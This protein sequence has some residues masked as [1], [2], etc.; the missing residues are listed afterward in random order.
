MRAL[1]TGGNGFMGSHLVEGLHREGWDVVSVH[2]GVALHHAPARVRVIREGI[3]N[4]GAMAEALRGVDVV[5]HLAWSGVHVSSN[6]DLRGHVEANLLPSLSLFET[7]LEAGVRRI[8]FVSSGGTVYGRPETLPI[9]EDHPTRPIN[10]YGA[11]KLAV[12]RY[13]DLHRHLQGLETVILRPSVAY[14][15]RQRPDGLQGAVAVFL[16]RIAR[17]EPLVIWGDGSSSRD[18]FHVEDFVHAASLAG[19]APVSG[20][21]FNISGGRGLRLDTLVDL[22]QEVSGRKAEVRFE[23]ARVFDVPVLELDLKRAQQLLGWQP[24]IDFEEGLARTWEWLKEQDFG[25]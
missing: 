22:L 13:L 19:T 25:G 12:E 8:V 11:T 21:V 10:A 20:E 24:K 14:G 4:R 6:Q 17:G 15:E 16:G 1:V 3:G 2:R 18:F 9:P 23:P 7:C 5:F